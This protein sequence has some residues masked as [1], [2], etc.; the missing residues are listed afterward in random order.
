MN[1]LEGSEESNTNLSG[2]CDQ[3]DDSDLKAELPN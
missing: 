2:S 1:L 3:N